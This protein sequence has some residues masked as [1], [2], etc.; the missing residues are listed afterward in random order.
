MWPDSAV[1]R[2]LQL[3][4]GIMV[5]TIF[6]TQGIQPVSAQSSPASDQPGTA[7]NLPIDTCPAGMDSVLPSS[8][9][10]T[11]DGWTELS[12]NI[13]GAVSVREI[14]PAGLDPTQMTD[15]EVASHHLPPHPTAT[16]DATSWSSLVRNLGSQSAQNLCESKTV[17]FGG[18]QRYSPNWGGDE[19]RYQSSYQFNGVKANFTQQALNTY[20]GSYSSCAAR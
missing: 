7:A 10:V 2:G 20:C 18:T 13:G 6:V 8:T 4:P 9:T 5:A 15:Q 11:T 14:A 16:A 19:M 12:Y 1:R 3:L 17:R